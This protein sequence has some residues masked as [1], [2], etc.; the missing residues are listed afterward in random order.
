MTLST[1]A[2]ATTIFTTARVMI[3]FSAARWRRYYH[4]YWVESF[5]ASGDGNDTIDGAGNDYI[6][7][8]N[9][10]DSLTGG[11]GDDH[12]FGDTGN[13][14][15]YG[16]NGNDE[17]TAGDWNGHIGASYLDGGNG[18]DFLGS[19]YNGHD[20]LIGGAGDDRLQVNISEHVSSSFSLGDHQATLTGGAGSDTFV[21]DN[22]D[23]KLAASY[24]PTT[25]NDHYTITDF[26][27]NKDSLSIVYFQTPTY[28]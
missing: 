3:Q 22:V 12:L 28:M 13:D 5:F 16:G 7:G 8:G 10:N 24:T 11:A 18:N 1:V 27:V 9:G 15:I 25:A 19:G 14:T 23:V 21:F 4:R 17:L 20:T 2:L 26:N 6:F